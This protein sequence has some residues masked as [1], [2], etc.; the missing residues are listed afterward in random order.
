MTSVTCDIV[1][2]LKYIFNMNYFQAEIFRLGM[3]SPYANGTLSPNRKKTKL[4]GPVQNRA[5]SCTTDSN[6]LAPASV[7][8]VRQALAKPGSSTSSPSGP[9]AGTE[10][11]EAGLYR[12]RGL[13]RFKIKHGI[14][15]SLSPSRIT[16]SFKA[17]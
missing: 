4:C 11:R 1:C 17:F 2:V 10:E 5:G 9:M 6:T 14:Q 13:H 8:D 12:P 7:T 3:L 16:L 15:T